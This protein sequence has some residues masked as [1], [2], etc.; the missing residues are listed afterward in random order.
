MTRARSCGGSRSV[1]SHGIEE[2][3]SS[4][5]MVVVEVA[6]GKLN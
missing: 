4:T 6:D 3:S 2:K 1:V 5:G